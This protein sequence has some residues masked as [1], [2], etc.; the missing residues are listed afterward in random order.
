MYNSGT[1]TIASR[2]VSSHISTSCN[3]PR[4]TLGET[5]EMV[6]RVPC[7]NPTGA[8]FPTSRVLIANAGSGKWNKIGASKDTTTR[9][10]PRIGESMKPEQMTNALRLGGASAASLTAIGVENDSARITNGSDLGNALRTQ[11]SKSVKDRCTRG[12]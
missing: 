7:T 4:R 9:T 3:L 11:R 5:D 1:V 12:G 8:S 6:V 2:A 10:R